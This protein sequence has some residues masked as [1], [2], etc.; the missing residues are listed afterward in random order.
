MITKQL[1]KKSVPLNINPYL[2]NKIFNEK[3][4]ILKPMEILN[5]GKYRSFLKSYM[6]KKYAVENIIF[7]EEVE[8]FKILY[9]DEKRRKR[10]FQ[11]YNEFL[12]PGSRFELNISSKLMS[13]CVDNLF[14]ND[15][16]FIFFF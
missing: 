14:G 12:K 16:G 13:Q 5:D 1:K 10:A 11:I 8:I 6:I 15:V 3:V 4:P 9:D 2:G 7:Y